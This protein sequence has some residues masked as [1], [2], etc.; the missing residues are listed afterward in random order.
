[1]QLAG[2]QLGFSS[3]LNKVTN[4]A[5]YIRRYLALNIFYTIAPWAM[6]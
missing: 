2:P 1:M 5:V 6:V 3:Y 4:K